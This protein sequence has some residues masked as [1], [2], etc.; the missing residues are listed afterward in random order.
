MLA[1]VDG[2]PLRYYGLVAGTTWPDIGV[3][4]LAERLQGQHGALDAGQLRQL[5]ARH[6]GAHYFVVTDFV[7]SPEQAS[8]RGLPRRA[9]PGGGLGR[10]IASTTWPSAAVPPDRGRSACPSLAGSG[11]MGG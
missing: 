7:D 3:D 1:P 5:A 9:L 8:L 6:R 11:R 10:S 4:V 2:D